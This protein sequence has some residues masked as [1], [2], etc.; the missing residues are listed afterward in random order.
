[1]RFLKPPGSGK[2]IDPNTTAPEYRGVPLRVSECGGFFDLTD[3][4]RDVPVI[5][6]DVGGTLLTNLLASTKWFFECLEGVYY[7]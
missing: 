7:L 1:M 2:R 4:W 6:L 3:W 5:G